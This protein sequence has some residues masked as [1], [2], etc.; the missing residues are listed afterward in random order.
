MRTAFE[1]KICGLVR[2]CDVELAAELGADYL[3][4]VLAPHSPRRVSLESLRELTRGLTGSG[5]RIVAVMAD[6]GREEILRA[7]EVAD[8]IQLHGS[9]PPELMESLP[10]VRFWKAFHLTEQAEVAR[11]SG[12]RVE[13]FVLDAASGGSGVRCDWSVAADAARRWPVM[14]AGGISAENVADAVGQV[15]PA[16]VDL[17]SSL[18]SSPGVKSKRK[19]MDFFK[20]VKELQK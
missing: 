12:Y 5:C 4:F 18:E 14:L 7:A 9:E 20:I 1:V 8:R 13:R 19:M 2:R 11:L 16:G 6:P 10:E 15:K 17:S 3:G